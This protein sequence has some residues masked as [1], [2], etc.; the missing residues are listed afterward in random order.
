[1]NF[2]STSSSAPEVPIMSHPTFAA[3][4]VTTVLT[5]DGMLVRLNGDLDARA[6]P[7]LR[8]ALLVT[9][10]AGCDDV[11]IDAQGVTSISEDALAVLLAA[12]AWAIDTGARLG[13]SRMSDPLRNEIA[14]LDISMLLPMLAPAGE[15]VV[16]SRPAV[17]A[18]AR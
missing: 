4:T 10:P 5:E 11:I 8:E 2:M 1:M 18:L 13:F 17:L 6:L 3:V 12:G 7:K 15:R 16:R 14:Y 9:R